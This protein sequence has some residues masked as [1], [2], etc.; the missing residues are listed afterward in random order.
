MKKILALGFAALSMFA[1][2]A[3]DFTVYSDGNLGQNLTFYNWYNAG[4]DFLATSPTDDGTVWTLA[5]Q[6][7][8]G[9]DYS[10]GL[11]VSANN[12]YIGKLATSTLTFEYYPTQACTL[13]VRVTC[14]G[15]G[16]QDYTITI[17]ADN[18]NKWN[19]V[20]INVSES[21]ANVAPKWAAYKGDGKGYIFGF[22]VWKISGEGDAK[23]YFKDVVYKNIN[24][25]WVKPEVEVEV[26]PTVTA[27]TIAPENVKAII[28]GTYEPASNFNFTNGGWGETTRA[29]L[30][31]DE[32]GAPVYKLTNFNYIGMVDGR[33]DVTGFDYLHVEFYP[34]TE[35]K[36]GFTPIS[37]AIGAEGAHEAPFLADPVIQGEW[38]KYDVPLSHWTTA[39]PSDK[40]CVDFSNIFQMKF[41]PGTGGE[42]YIA[43]VYFWKDTRIIPTVSFEL[44]EVTSS[45]ATITY[46]STLPEELAGATVR[47]YIDNMPV[48]ENPYTWDEL[49]PNTFYSHTLKAIASLDDDDDYESDPVTIAFTTL[50]EGA[51]DLIYSDIYKAEFKNAYLV[52]EDASMAR[53]F[54]VSMPWEVVYYADGTAKYSVD[55]TDVANFT[56]LSPQIYWNGFKALSR[57]GDTDI[58][59]YNFGEQP[60]D[61][62]TQISHYIAYA[63]GN[64]DQR[65]PY[66]AWGQENTAPVL[67]DATAMTV[68]ASKTMA[69]I[70]EPIIL[71]A[72]PTDANGYY[73]P[74]GDVEYTV[75]GGDYTLNN[76]IL[77]LTG[78]KGTRT[79]T[80]TMDDI[81]ATVDVT[82]WASAEAENVIAGQI[83]VT[84][85]ENIGGGSLA[86]VTDADR[87]SELIWNCGTTQEHYLIYDLAKDYYIEAIDLLFEGAYA[88]QFTVTLSNTAPAELSEVAPAAELSTEDVVFTPAKND[89]QHYFMN[90]TAS[91]HRYVTLRTTQALNTG[92]GIKVRDLKVYAVEAETVGIENI[93][94]SSDAPARY[95]RLDGVEAAGNL[96]PGLYI[97]V[98]GSKAEKVYIR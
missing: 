76:G 54:Y 38:N 6:D 13:D 87:N 43:N 81:T 66:T 36:F 52:G 94:T 19:P 49:E 61:G 1:A 27:P 40:A 85:E 5:K 25:D 95:F 7:T 28:S 9:A 29:K 26:A 90:T 78:E 20:S 30:L 93:E 73:L 59:E 98:Q 91:S 31:A 39:N 12:N 46:D 50:R 23:I 69:K 4:C 42:G 62:A 60:L 14:D 17:T 71:T 80:A 79:I 58:W 96:V 68:S 22:H 45:S 77:T 2:Q 33:L 55:L 53:S 75:T 72:V 34:T 63:G 74:A 3:E 8:G 32:N 67:G 88:T 41:E 70:G 11:E 24:T 56:G 65:T 57:Q 37:P 35:T 10:G 84:D 51:V 82:A 18:L 48:S 16:E 83:G 97:K 21:Y 86:N 15:E 89:T 64:L 44:T 92:W 47:Y